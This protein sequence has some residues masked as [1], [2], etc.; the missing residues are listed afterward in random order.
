MLPVRDPE[1]VYTVV[2]V[3]GGTQPPNTS[4]TGMAIRRFPFRFSRLCEREIVFSAM[5]SLTFLSAMGKSPSGTAT[6]RQ[7]SKVKKSVGITSPAWES[8]F[9]A[10]S[11]SLQPMKATTIPF[12]FLVTATGRKRSHEILT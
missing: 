2:L 4:G 1:Q 3:N 7:K 10:E 12:L 8:T 9:C 11:A 6:H 5:S